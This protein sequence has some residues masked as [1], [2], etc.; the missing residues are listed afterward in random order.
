MI[1]DA[2]VLK[3]RLT[4]EE[5]LGE[6]VG[7]GLWHGVLCLVQVFQDPLQVAVLLDELQGSRRPNACK[8]FQSGHSMGSQP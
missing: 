3:Q 1:G 6:L 7:E 5:L 4:N 8:W 2:L